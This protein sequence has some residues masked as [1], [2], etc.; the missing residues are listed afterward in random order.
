MAET[1]FDKPF[2]F[3]HQVHYPQNIKLNPGDTITST[4]TFNNTTDKGVPFGESTDTEMCYQF[5]FAWP[6]HSLENHAS[7]LI[8][9]SN[10][11]W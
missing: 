1:V 7:S 9:A 2:D 5:T 8:G 10:T 6:A 11:C 4:C 3:N